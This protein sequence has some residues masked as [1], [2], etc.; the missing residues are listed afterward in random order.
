MPVLPPDFVDVHVD[1]LR[2]TDKAW[3]VT[4]GD[5]TVWLPKSHVETDGL[6]VCCSGKIFLP[7]WLAHDRGLI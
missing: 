2:E 4:D 6:K 7:E 1:I 3:Q 5:V